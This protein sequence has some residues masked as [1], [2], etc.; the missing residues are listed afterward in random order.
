MTIN[1]NRVNYLKY[2]TDKYGIVQL[3]MIDFIDLL[4]DRNQKIANYSF[5]TDTSLIAATILLKGPA[6][7]PRL[8]HTWKLE[9]EGG[10]L[11]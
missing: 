11:I 6:E 10:C 9:A 2:L 8:V 3:S 1:N 7:K 5:L 4:P